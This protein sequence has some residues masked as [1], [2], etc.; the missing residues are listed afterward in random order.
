[1]PFE[2]LKECEE[3][4]ISILKKDA[5]LTSSQADFGRVILL[6]ASR[7]RA[8]CHMNMCEYATAFA[9]F[10][11]SMDFAKNVFGEDYHP[12]KF[13]ARMGEVRTMQYQGQFEKGISALN[14][15]LSDHELWISATHGSGTD[16]NDLAKQPSTS[17]LEADQF[18]GDIE[19]VLEPLLQYPLPYD[20]AS[21]V[22]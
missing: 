16:L 12:S 2:L 22:E 11:E 15:L 19:G 8:S 6:E 1:M 4:L 5:A 21:R 14:R 9:A 20:Y 17:T 13:A 10:K 3:K 18:F 7:L